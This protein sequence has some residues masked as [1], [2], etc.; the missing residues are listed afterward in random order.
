LALQFA[1]VATLAPAPRSQFGKSS[2]LIS[3]NSGEID[4]E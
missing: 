1:T 2:A 3:Q 4:S